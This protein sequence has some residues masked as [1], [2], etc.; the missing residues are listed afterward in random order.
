[1]LFGKAHERRHATPAASSAS[2]SG[3]GWFDLPAAKAVLEPLDPELRQRS[4]DVFALADGEAKLA[5]LGPSELDALLVPLKQLA[6]ELAE[7]LERDADVVRRRHAA[8]WLR[9]SL[10]WGAFVFGMAWVSFGIF[11]RRNLARDALVTTSSAEAKVRANP[12]AL[13]DGDRKNLG[14]HTQKGRGESATIDLGAIHPVRSV[15][16][17]NRFDCCQNRA[18][19]LRLEVSTDGVTYELVDRRTEAFTLWKVALPSK[20]ARFLRLTDEA[21]N[22]FHLAEVEVY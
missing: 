1:M 16:I 3:P 11:G 7:P 18:L 22:F 17:Y 12:R 10:A 15:E 8:R 21:T 20:P 4:S 19:P 5:T 14:F 2:S 13:V 6:L 9:R